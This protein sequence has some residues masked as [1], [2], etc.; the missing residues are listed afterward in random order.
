MKQ[1]MEEIRK[2]M[3]LRFDCFDDHFKIVQDYL[4]PHDINL[5]ENDIYTIYIYRIYKNMLAP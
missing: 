2:S 1:F 5:V 3:E 4:S